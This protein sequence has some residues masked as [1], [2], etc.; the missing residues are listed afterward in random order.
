M[1]PRQHLRSRRPPRRRPPHRRTATCTDVPVLVGGGG[2]A[3]IPCVLRAPHLGLVQGR[4]RRDV[5]AGGAVPPGQQLPGAP[6]GPRRG[7][8]AVRRA[9]VRARRVR[10]CARGQRVDRRRTQHRPLPQPHH[11]AS[12]RRDAPLAP[13]LVLF[14]QPQRLARHTGRLDGGVRQAASGPVLHPAPS[15]LAARKKITKK[16]PHS[17]VTS[18]YLWHFMLVDAAA[19]PNSM[20]SLCGNT[21]T[22][23]GADTFML[24]TDVVPPTPA[25]P[26]AENKVS[27]NSPDMCSMQCGSDDNAPAAAV[28]LGVSKS[29]SI[30]FRQSWYISTSCCTSSIGVLMF[31]VAKATE[32]SEDHKMLEL[33]LASC[34]MFN[35]NLDNVLLQQPWLPPNLL[36]NQH[37][38]CSMHAM[39]YA[40]NWVFNRGRYTEGENVVAVREMRKLS[41]TPVQWS[42]TCCALVLKFVWSPLVSAWSSVTILYRWSDRMCTCLWNEYFVLILHHK[43]SAFQHLVFV[44]QR[45]NESPYSLESIQAVLL[46]VF[47]GAH[48]WWRNSEMFLCQAFIKFQQHQQATSALVYLY[49]P[50][51]DDRYCQL[52]VQR[53]NPCYSGIK[54]TLEERRPWSE[55]YSLVFQIGDELVVQFH[56]CAPNKVRLSSDH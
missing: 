17:R 40:N 33:C 30:A 15:C 37:H 56:Y 50:C 2:A 24:E 31:G 10:V 7:A 21:N 38:G 52:V 19:T 36:Q 54:G 18:E 42:S 22:S 1:Y 41:F 46:L 5:A 47:M 13:P 26:S 9:G 45:E 51:I 14:R 55:K 23:R 53:V 11:A 48:W 29:C 34:L 8:L 49:R 27:N 35:C 25:S 16:L 43:S 39:S 6:G 20:M 3:V 44:Q 28:P 4:P 32:I 12:R